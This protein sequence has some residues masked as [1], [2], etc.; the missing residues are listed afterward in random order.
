MK[1]KT[2]KEQIKLTKLVEFPLTYEENIK[3]LCF[4]LNLCGYYAKVR[5]KDEFYVVD[6]YTDR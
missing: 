6:V 4:A 2:T 5:K 3:R 1:R